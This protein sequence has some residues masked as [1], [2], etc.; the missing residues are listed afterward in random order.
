[1]SFSSQISNLHKFSFP[2]K[3][4]SRQKRVTWEKDFHRQMEAALESMEGNWVVNMAG[5]HGGQNNMTFATLLCDDKLLNAT[6]VLVYTLLNYAKTEYP[7]TV[8]TLPEVSMKAKM[9]LQELG[10]QV[11]NV[12]GLKYPFKLNE[13]RVRDNKPCRLVLSSE[14]I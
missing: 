2:G 12:T 5:A 9:Q 11:L 7:V 6:S 13:G 14:M 10:A 3:A 4:E 1:M 8:I